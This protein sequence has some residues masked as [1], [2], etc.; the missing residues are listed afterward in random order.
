VAKPLAE[1]ARSYKRIR[2]LEAEI[3]EAPAKQKDIR[4][5]ILSGRPN[6]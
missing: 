3:N 4:R 5:W 6:K 2:E 1:I